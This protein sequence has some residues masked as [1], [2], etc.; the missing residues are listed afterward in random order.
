MKEFNFFEKLIQ[1]TKTII[2][3]NKRLAKLLASL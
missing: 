2:V 3:K 1:Y